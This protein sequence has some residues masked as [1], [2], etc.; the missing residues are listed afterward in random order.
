[1][2][3]NSERRSKTHTHTSTVEL[4]AT[5]GLGESVRISPFRLS[6]IV[7][8]YDE[9]GRGTVWREGGRKCAMSNQLLRRIQM[10]YIH[11]TCTPVHII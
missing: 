7:C 8:F 3:F 4:T 5:Y 2:Q 6:E 1:M 10:S 11:K 9:G